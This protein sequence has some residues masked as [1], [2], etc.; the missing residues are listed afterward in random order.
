MQWQNTQKRREEGQTW[1]LA[2]GVWVQLMGLWRRD[3]NIPVRRPFSLI[4]R[5]QAGLLVSPKPAE[6]PG[7]PHRAPFL[8]HACY[9]VSRACLSPQP[10][11]EGGRAPAGHGVSALWGPRLRPR[12][13]GGEAGPRAFRPHVGSGWDL[14]SETGRARSFLRGSHGFDHPPEFT[15][16]LSPWKPQAAEPLLMGLVWLPRLRGRFSPQVGRAPSAVS[17]HRLAG[18]SG[19][20]CAGR[21]AS[22]AARVP[23]AGNA[24]AHTPPFRMLVFQGRPGGGLRGS[25]AR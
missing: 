6:P 11:A 3:A 19:L 21:W 7:F 17:E 25:R 16:P 23:P 14:P 1:A 13:S 10:P 5:S 18:H 2:R 4:R 15:Q 8:L 20:P 22:R 9:R 12:L 24:A